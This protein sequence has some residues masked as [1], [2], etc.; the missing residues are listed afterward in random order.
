MQPT[1]LIILHPGFEELEA[2]A[3]IDLLARAGVKV[4]QA[5]VSDTL[6]VPGRNGM[7][8]QAEQPLESIPA[9]QRFDAVILPGGPGI[10]HIRKHPQI[11]AILQRHHAED[12]VIACIC[13]APLLLLDAGLLN[14]LSYTAHPATKEELAQA[15]ENP[16]VVDGRIITSR[17][18]GTATAFGLAIVEQLTSAETRTE[19]AGSICY[20]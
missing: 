5:A 6:L 9:D 12:K 13:A 8:L 11:C 1:A 20:L 10:N 19:V 16:V 14:G 15:Q 17:G 3:P 7:T 4:T 2:V 18:A